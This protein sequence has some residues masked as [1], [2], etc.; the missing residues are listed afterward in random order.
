MRHRDGTLAEH[1]D[2]PP[3]QG[4]YL[5]AASCNLW[6]NIMRILSA[7]RQAAEVRVPI[8]VTFKVHAP[9]S[10]NVIASQVATNRTTSLN[11]ERLL[12]DLMS[13]QRLRKIIFYVLEKGGSVSTERRLRETL[14]KFHR[15]AVLE[16]C[17][18]A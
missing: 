16:V 10:I 4:L 8:T 7:L 6:A 1:Y 14:P 17:E 15:A 13:Q 3:L 5:H 9:R 18:Q 2:S 12:T 11:A